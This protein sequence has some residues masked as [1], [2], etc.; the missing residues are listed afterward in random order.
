[1]IEEH[2]SVANLKKAIGEV[3]DKIRQNLI[4][5]IVEDLMIYPENLVELKKLIKRF[6]ELELVPDFTVRLPGVIHKTIIKGTI[7][8]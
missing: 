3:Y 8:P 6:D 2:H 1:V 4:Y 5:D 7:E